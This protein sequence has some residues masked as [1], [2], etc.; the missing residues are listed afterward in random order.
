MR[1]QANERETKH[2]NKASQEVTE[3]TLVG[4]DLLWL[5]S[6]RTKWAQESGHCDPSEGQECTR[7]RRSSYIHIH[8]HIHTE[9]NRYMTTHTHTPVFQ[10]ERTNRTLSTL[11]LPPGTLQTP[12]PTTN[13]QH[14]G[15]RFPCRGTLQPPLGTLCGEPAW[16]A[17]VFQ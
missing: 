14:S 15:E 5:P 10:A 16:N 1:A 8:T 3:W 17:A 2:A 11:Q 13:S 4:D 6:A 9:A 7:I 12:Q